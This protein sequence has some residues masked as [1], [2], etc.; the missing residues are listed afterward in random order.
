MP[1]LDALAAYPLAPSEIILLNGE[2]FAPPPG[3]T[4][5]LALLHTAGAVSAAALARAMLAAAFLAAE[6]AGALRLDVRPKPTPFGPSKVRTLYAEPGEADPAWPAHS[7][8][9]RLRLPAGASLEV[10]VVVPGLL[11]ADAPNPWH[12]TA[13]VVKR[14]LARRGLLETVEVVQFG[15][16]KAQAY[17]L[18]EATRALAAQGPVETVR[19]LLSACERDR[20]EVWAQL[21]QQID[22]GLRARLKP[23]AP[24]PARKAD[25]DE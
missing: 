7:L 18:P 6:Q 24:A 16:V 5:P 19:G 17:R 2:A 9:A 15:F 3:L 13:E 11:E 10:S 22:A 25:E 12:H 1:E 21:G 4:D 8:E 23:G 14:G 20:P